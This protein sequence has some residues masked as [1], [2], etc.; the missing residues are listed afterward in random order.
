[1]PQR[2]IPAPRAHA[3]WSVSAARGQVL[4]AG[5]KHRPR[6][7]PSPLT[8]RAVP[9][10]PTNSSGSLW[11]RS[12]CQGLPLGKST[13]IAEGRKREWKQ[14][15]GRSSPGRWPALAWAGGSDGSEPASRVLRPTGGTGQALLGSFLSVLLSAGQRPAPSDAQSGLCSRPALTV[16][17]GG[18]AGVCGRSRDLQMQELAGHCAEP[19]APPW[20]SVKHLCWAS[21]CPPMGGPQVHLGRP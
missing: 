10:P 18:R 11:E 17:Y 13:K 1:M 7:S 15:G 4:G 3:T 5:A 16:A 9:D 21:W 6:P 2:R 12:V 19:Q 14:L 8:A 20:V